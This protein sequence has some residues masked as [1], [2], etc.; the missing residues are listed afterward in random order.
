MSY[1]RSLGH[2]D[3]QDHELVKGRNISGQN[4]LREGVK[5]LFTKSVR[6]GGNPLPPFAHFF[7]TKIVYTSNKMLRRPTSVILNVMFRAPADKSSQQRP[8]HNIRFCHHIYYNPISTPYLIFVRNARNAVS[9][10]FFLA[11]CKQ[12][13]EK[14][15]NYCFGLHLYRS[16]NSLFYTKGSRHS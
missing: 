5:N 6:K 9:V 13:P 15:E 16:R 10:N 7:S 14:R 11:E 1:P 12:I 4:V 8:H 2:W 3:S